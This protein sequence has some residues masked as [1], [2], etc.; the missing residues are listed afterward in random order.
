[1]HCKKGKLQPLL[2][3]PYMKLPLHY[4]KGDK[5]LGITVP[6]QSNFNFMVWELVTLAPTRHL[7]HNC[8]VIPARY[9]VNHIPVRT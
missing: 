1:M 2:Y 3:N 8:Y 6:N 4:L 5:T 9:P 7:V